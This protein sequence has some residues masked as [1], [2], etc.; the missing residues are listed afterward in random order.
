MRVGL[1]LL[2]LL[3]P[4]LLLRRRIGMPAAIASWSSGVG[5]KLSSQ[6]YCF[7]GTPQVLLNIRQLEYTVLSYWSI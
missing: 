6:K 1:A 7:C 2:V 4:K 3:L 5:C